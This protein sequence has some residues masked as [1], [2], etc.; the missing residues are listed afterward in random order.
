MKSNTRLLLIMGVAVVVLAGGALAVTRMKAAAAPPAYLTQ[1]AAL[2]DVERTVLASGT[3]QPL[4]VVD[5]GAQAS[6]QIQSLKVNLGDQVK[7]GQL[8][9]VIDPATQQNSL[10]AAQ[11][12]IVQM[13]A[14][15]AAQRAGLARDQLTLNRNRLLV[16]QGAVPQATLDLSEATVQVD[17]ANIEALDA[18]IQAAQNS[19]DKAN[20]DLSRT[21][22]IAPIDGV[23]SNIPVREGQTV[24]AVQQA[25]TIVSISRLDVM[26]VKAQIS[27]ADVIHVAPGQSVYFTILGDPDRRY[28]A[29]LRQLEPA[30]P[31][32]GASTNAS[33]SSSGSA[34]YYNALFDVPNPD[35]QLRASMTAQVNVILGQAKGVVTVPSSALIKGDNGA[36]SIKV[37]GA[38]GTVT[39]RPVTIG[40]NNNVLAEVKS[41]LKV[42]DKVVT[43]T[44][45]KAQAAAQRLAAMT[46]NR[47]QRGGGR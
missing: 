5:V 4:V 14:Q 10:K 12:Q 41:G 39:D 23:V 20:V 35:G 22:I 13:S 11:A 44:L 3:L 30:P 31:S 1:P 26:T 29:T 43:A 19:V 17:Q 38:D 40:L 9:A 7:K 25:P 47:P 37:M 6:G 2:G 33:A 42:G 24:N 46:A 34:I 45:T 15:R 36:Y 32:S 21:N 18:Q 16:P 8:L 28:Y 27:E